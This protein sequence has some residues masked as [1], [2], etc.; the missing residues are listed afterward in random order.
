MHKNEEKGGRK[1][2][3]TKWIRH[4]GPTEKLSSSLYSPS[5]HPKCMEMSKRGWKNPQN[6]QVMKI[7]FKSGQ[8]CVLTL[9]SSIVQGKKQ[10]QDKRNNPHHKEYMKIWFNKYTIHCTHILILH[11]G[12]IKRKEDRQSTKWIRHKGLI[13]KVRGSL[14]SPAINPQFIDIRTKSMG[15]AIHKTIKTVR[16]DSKSE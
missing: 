14:Y 12:W 8:L 15:K 4:E 11:S 3:S 9:Y 6:E 2:Q 7:W 5:R 13:Q 16:S 1:R 10:E